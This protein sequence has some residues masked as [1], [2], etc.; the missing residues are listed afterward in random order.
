MAVS[1][2]VSLSIIVLS[3]HSAQH[4]KTKVCFVSG[5]GDKKTFSPVLPPKLSDEGK[6]RQK[7]PLPD[8]AARMCFATCVPAQQI[9]SSGV[10]AGLDS[11]NPDAAELRLCGSGTDVYAHMGDV[12]PQSS[13][14]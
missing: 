13:S 5:A 4:Q 10:S 11:V 6:F 9:P 3:L 14:A 2:P 8:S 7:S 12:S 1:R